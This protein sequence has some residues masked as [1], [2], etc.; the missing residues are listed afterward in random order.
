MRKRNLSDLKKH[1]VNLNFS[2]CHHP[3]IPVEVIKDGT[4]I[5][6]CGRNTMR[7]YKK[8]RNNQKQ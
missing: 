3:R 6:W 8:W 5:G 2:D 7:T 4:T 1:G